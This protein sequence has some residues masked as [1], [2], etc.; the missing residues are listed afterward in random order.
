M[1][2]FES[3][4]SLGYSGIVVVMTALFIATVL[5]NVL[6]MHKRP[7][8]MKM[9]LLLVVGALFV[10]STNFLAAERKK[11]MDA[12]RDDGGLKRTQTK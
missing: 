11:M 2:F 9:V 3:F 8:W 5:F 10:V 7:F 1:Q 12:I 6:K 4:Y